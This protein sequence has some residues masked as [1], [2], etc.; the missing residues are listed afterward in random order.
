MGIELT[1]LLVPLGPGELAPVVESNG[2]A[3]PSSLGRP[4][5]VAATD[6]S[7]AGTLARRQ[8]VDPSGPGASFVVELELVTTYLQRLEPR[9]VGRR[10]AL[11]LW[12]PAAALPGL[13]GRIARPIQLAHAFYGPSYRE[14]VPPGESPYADD[15][16][17]FLALLRRLPEVIEPAVLPMEG[18]TGLFVDEERRWHLIRRQRGETLLDGSETEDAPHP[19]PEPSLGEALRRELLGDARLWL[20]SNLGFWRA[21]GK[22]CARDAVDLVGPLRRHF[23]HPSP[24][25]RATLVD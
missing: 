9:V 5:L 10:P 15:V 21:S 8:A 14:E 17:L 4:W 20:L 12:F 7:H 16:R 19:V 18:P 3:L 25:L 1:R 6:P 24:T 2:E 22:L 23:P 11:E 13:S